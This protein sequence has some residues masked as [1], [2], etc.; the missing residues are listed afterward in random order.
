MIEILIL[1][2]VFLLPFARQLKPLEPTEQSIRKILVW[3]LWMAPEWRVPVCLVILL[4]FHCGLLSPYLQYKD[5][6]EAIQ[7]LAQQ[8]NQDA[9]QIRAFNA[10][11]FD[12]AAV[13]AVYEFNKGNYTNCCVYSEKFYASALRDNRDLTLKPLYF[14]AML[15]TNICINGIYSPEALGQFENSLNEMTNDINRAVNERLP[16][17]GAQAANIDQTV[18]NVRLILL[19]VPL[20]ETNFVEIVI[21]TL[22]N[23]QARAEQ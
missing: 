11:H 23:L 3:K 14:C 21:R 10:I 20:S 16:A 19:R 8:T 15:K 6:K 5:D 4:A 9:I 2:V 13:N 1:I 17:L 12:S 22:T 7:T 18:Y